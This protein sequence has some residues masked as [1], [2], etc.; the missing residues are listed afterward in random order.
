MKLVHSV[1]LAL[2]AVAL[3]LAVGCG[4][5]G[6]SKNNQGL[7]VG[8]DPA[9]ASSTWPVISWK[10]VKKLQLDVQIGSVFLGDQ[11]VS[12][13]RLGILYVHGADSL[14]AVA[15]ARKFGM[16]VKA[17]SKPN[18]ERVEGDVWRVYFQPDS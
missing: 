18:A 5:Q 4:V 11:S 9:Q 10:Q 15:E 13:P 7:Y 16:R 8:G 6:V 2:L 12:T 17:D 1:A 14:T 3:V